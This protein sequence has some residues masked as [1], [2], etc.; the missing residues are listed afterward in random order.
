[1][2]DLIVQV[3]RI[4]EIRPHPD[5]EATRIELAIVKGWQTVV[6]VGKYHAGDVA[7]YVPPD[8]MLKP[9]VS[10]H[11]GVTQYLGSGGRVKSARLRGAMSFGFLADVE[12]ICGEG[13]IRSREIAERDPGWLTTVWVPEVGDDVA[14]YYSI[15][16]WEPPSTFNTAELEPEHPAFRRYTDIQLFENYPDTIDHG[17]EVVIT[18]KIHGTNSRIGLIR[19]DQEGGEPFLVAGTH[20]SQVR[21]DVESFYVMPLRME[22]VQNLLRDIFDATGARAVIIFGEIYGWVQSLRYGHGKG[23]ISFRAFD[24]SVDG[25][26]MDWDDVVAVCEK[27]GVEMVPVLYRGPFDPDV[28]RE[29]SGG[30]TTVGGDHIREGV[31][32]H[33][34]VE[35]ISKWGHR[36][37]VKR[38]SDQ[39]R[40]KAD[41]I[42]DSH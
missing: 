24:I 10:D 16:K 37:I 1:M 29:L 6:P 42:S 3:V 26:M 39:Y 31:V 30:S 28:L 12:P 41:R 9:E 27:H 8:C 22:S 38:I 40:Q 11:W 20:E 32:C 19:S 25:R 7:I 36:A 13:F 21:Q 14:D 2:S 17:D 4:D 33:P 35:K 18:E 34:V 23:R 15:T 5:P